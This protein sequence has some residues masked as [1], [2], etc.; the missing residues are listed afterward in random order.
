MSA[1]MSVVSSPWSVAIAR[2]RRSQATDYGLLT[3]DF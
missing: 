3:T 2:E 1:R